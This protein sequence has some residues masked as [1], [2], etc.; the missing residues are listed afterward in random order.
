MYDLK[1]EHLHSHS[2]FLLSIFA[3]IIA[4]CIAMCIAMSG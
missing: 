2:K 3:I 1:R 4:M